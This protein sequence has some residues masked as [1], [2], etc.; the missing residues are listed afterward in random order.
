MALVPTVGDLSF[1]SNPSKQ[2]ERYDHVIAKFQELFQEKPQVL[3]RAP[4]RVNLIGDHIDYCYFSVL[5]MA[6]E[7]DVIAAV[8]DSKDTSITISNTD[9]KFATE[10][11]ELPADGS[12]VD[13]DLNKHTWGNYFKCGLLVAHKYITETYPEKTQNGTK[14]LHGLHALFD[15]TVPTGG[16]L[17]SS[18]AF[19]IAATL[20]VLKVNGVTEIS[21][22]DLTRITVVCEHYVGLNN[23]GMDQCASVCGEPSKVLLILFKPELLATPFELPKSEPE[24]VFLISN[25]L[26]TA[27]KT[28]TAPTNYNLRVVEVAVA[29]DILVHRFGLKTAQDSN[30]KTASLR[31]AFDAYFTQKLNQPEWDGVDINVGIE[32]LAKMLEVVEE[33]YSESEKAGFST[34]DAARATGKTAAD[35]EATYLKAFPVRFD[36]LKVYQR[37]KHVFSD[38]L[39]VLQTV[40]LARDFDGNSEAYL[41]QFGRLMNESQ[42]SCNILNNAS[43][44]DCEE[45]CKIARSNGS[46]GSRVT[47]AGWGGS[48]V[49]LTTVDKLGGLIEALRTQ[50][51]RKKFANIT[52]GELDEAIVVSKPAEGACVVDIL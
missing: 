51:Y 8:S 6:I 46:Y 40:K 48:L 23:G 14:P 36:A 11:F 19:C 29:A 44:P 16:G 35:F 30:L 26:V 3:V 10:T 20:A 17:S 22:K 13:I 52:E 28:E 4:G 50:Y 5:P 1:Y 41:R 15:G 21:K 25:S 45:L 47:G 2:H 34:E 7:V 42:D 9:A 24:S 37:T 31:G 18:A 43:S 49:H 32:R 12:L 27:N 39:R 38:S 33:L